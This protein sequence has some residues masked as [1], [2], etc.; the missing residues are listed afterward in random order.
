MA[1][2]VG[3]IVLDCLGLYCTHFKKT[4]LADDGDNPVLKKVFDIYLSFMQ[5]GQ[6]ET[7]YSHIFPA[8]RSFINN[9]SAVLFKGKAL[10][11]IASCIT[12]IFVGNAS[13]CGRL[14][15]ELLRCCS[16]R[17]PFIRQESC[18]I[19]Y[20]LMRSNFVFTDHG[21]LTR[22]HLQLIISV[23][24]M[25]GTKVGLS[26]AKFQESLS[27]INSYATSDKAMKGTG[28]KEK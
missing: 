20:L 21:G 5:I 25:L 28:K 26:S 19:L 18:A 15:Y 27:L 9:F 24:Q 6:S 10:F 12:V 14:C 8:I 17:L 11:E 1:T 7:L 3:L 13:L 23:S 16:S 22:V 4:M 2:E